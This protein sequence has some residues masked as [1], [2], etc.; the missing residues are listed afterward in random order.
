MC[1][2][3]RQLSL[4]AVLVEAAEVLDPRD[5][6]GL[7][8]AY[9][10]IGGAL[11]L[12]LRLAAAQ[13]VA[14][15]YRLESIEAQRLPNLD[16]AVLRAA[17]SIVFDRSVLSTL[18]LT[19]ERDT[20]DDG[21]VPTQGGRIALAV[22]LGSKI[23]ASSYEFSKYTAELE[24]AFSPVSSHALRVRTLAGLIQ[25]RTPFF[26]QFFARDHL[27]FAAGTE[28][29]PRVLGVNFSTDNDYDD[30][31]ITAG[32]DYSIPI[33]TSGDLVYR[34]YVYLGVDVAA[35]A[36]LDEIQE[37]ASGRGLRGRVPV[38]VDAGLRFDTFLGHFTLSAA[39]LVDLVL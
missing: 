16:P 5:P 39:Y 28:A 27:A 18:S 15:E 12:G 6:T 24:L 21:F 30:L 32:I 36:S 10:R 22:E 26:N 35:T 23:L 3:D 7:A 9:S 1:I 20:R 19:Y 29:L 4:A 11:G 14:L 17:P 34:A 37:D 33:I 2:R 8:L 38:S 25:G 13:R 31:L